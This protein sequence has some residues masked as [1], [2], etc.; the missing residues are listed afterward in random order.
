MNYYLVMKHF[1]M[2]DIPVLLTPHYSRAYKLV[3][4]LS[5]QMDKGEVYATK[6][7]QDLIGADIGSEL[8]S[9]SIVSFDINGKP[10][11]TFLGPKND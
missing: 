5:K 7:D 9:V 1:N 11:T 2:D 8:I 6:K 4:R 3:Q 10:K